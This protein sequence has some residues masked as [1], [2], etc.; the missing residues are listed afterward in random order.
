MSLTHGRT[1]QARR[2]PR[3]CWLAASLLLAASVTGGWWYAS[4]HQL[5]VPSWVSWRERQLSCDL[6]GDGRLETLELS[7][8]RVTVR[9]ESG[10]VLYESKPEWQVCDLLLG[11]VDRDGLSEFVMVVWRRG[12]YGSSRPFWETEPDLRMTQHLYVM[13]MQDGEVRPFWMGHELRAAVVEVA[14]DEQGRLLLTTDD[15]STTVW[16]WDVWG[17]TLEE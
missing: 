11:D 14:I 5:L 15:G 3:W 12:N 8:R 1:T 10:Q 4:S 17:F 9:A 16:Y 13:G 7:G 6:D 2:L